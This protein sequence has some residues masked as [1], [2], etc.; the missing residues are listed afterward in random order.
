MMAI[1]MDRGWST[2]W[3]GP[4]CRETGPIAQTLKA[5]AL[6]RQMFSFGGQPGICDKAE[7]QRAYMQGFIAKPALKSFV[8][9]MPPDIAIFAFEYS[10]GRLRHF[11][12]KVNEADWYSSAGVIGLTEEFV[13]GGTSLLSSNFRQSSMELYANDELNFLPTAEVRER[14]RDGAVNLMLIAH[15]KCVRSLPETV[16][17]ALLAGLEPAAT[18]F[19]RLPLA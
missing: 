2:P 13:E 16:L 4:L 10:T 9:H 11:R 5:I 18:R 17:S 15:P 8:R 3:S 12:T 1:A 7:R 19:R 14:F 6:T